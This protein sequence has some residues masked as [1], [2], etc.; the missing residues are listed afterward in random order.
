MPY[1]V[2]WLGTQHY[3]SNYFYFVKRLNYKQKNNKNISLYI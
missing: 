1:L 2:Y 3:Y